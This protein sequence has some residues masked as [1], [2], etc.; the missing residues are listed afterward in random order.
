MTS[1][2]RQSAKLRPVFSDQR[3]SINKKREDERWNANQ[4]IDSFHQS[5]GHGSVHSVCRQ[6]TRQIMA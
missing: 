2:S 4:G 1:L 6:N 3:E 5:H